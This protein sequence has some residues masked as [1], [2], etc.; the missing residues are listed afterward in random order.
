MSKNM[1]YWNR[2]ALEAEGLFDVERLEII[3]FPPGEAGATA[4]NNA[5]LTHL[6]DRA[7]DDSNMPLDTQTVKADTRI[8]YFDGAA[9]EYLT[10][11]TLNSIN[12]TYWAWPN[13]DEYV[14]DTSYT[15]EK[16]L[17]VNG[18]PQ[19]LRRAI[20]YAFNYDSMI[21]ALEG[22]AVQGG[23]TVGTANL[24]YNASVGGS[25]FDIDCTHAPPLSL[26]TLSIVSLSRVAPILFKK[27]L[28]DII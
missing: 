4:K 23:G 13:V 27:G 15:N 2:S 26:S 3:N 19:V 8:N 20:C 25:E 14:I 11:I 21:N 10:Q 16:G 17:P 22:K 9:S 1:D 6:I 12:E 28:T 5:L 24:Y 7:T 18:I